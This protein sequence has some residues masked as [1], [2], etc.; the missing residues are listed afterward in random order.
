MSNGDNRWAR[1]INPSL[2]RMPADHGDSSGVFRAIRRD[3]FER[4]GGYD[5]IGCGEDA[6]VAT[7]L[8]ILAV[9]A[10][11]AMCWHKNPDSLG[12]VFV[13]ARWHGKSDYLGAHTRR[14]WLRFSPP[15]S[16]LRASR[17]GL[18]ERS[19]WFALYR[20]IVDSGIFAGF[21]DREFLESSPFAVKPRVAILRGQALNPF[22]LQ[23]Y[24]PW[25]TP[26]T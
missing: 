23:S 5:D 17:A 14:N 3:A 2:R 20:L 1:F 7:K 25:S 15:V 8:G 19:F 6:T 12:E 4:V 11:G 13:S 26:T 21:V 16:L 24:E 10:D 18:R 9:R 22:E